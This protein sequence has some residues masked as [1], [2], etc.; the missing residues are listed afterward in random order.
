VQEFQYV[1][2]APNMPLRHREYAKD[3]TTKNAVVGCSQKSRLTDISFFPSPLGGAHGKQPSALYL[4]RLPGT[5]DAK[6]AADHASL[7]RMELEASWQNQA[8]YLYT[9]LLSLSLSRYCH[10]IKHFHVRS[11]HTLTPFNACA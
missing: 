9:P 2:L 7:G 1:V 3:I 5:R 4:G 8:R 10:H 11:C 6:A